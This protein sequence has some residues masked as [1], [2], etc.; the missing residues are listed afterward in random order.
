M[1]QNLNSGKESLFRKLSL[2]SLVSVY[3][4]ILVGGIVRSTGSGMGCPDWPK[5]FDQW[6]PPT[7]SEQLPE[8]YE[9]IYSAKRMAKNERFAKYLSFF[10]L[11]R[12]AEKILNRNSV[13]E[14]TTFNKYKTWTEYFN[15]VLGVLV[16][17][18]ITVT[19]ISSLPLIRRRTGLFVIASLAFIMVVFQGWIGSVVVST[20]L[21]PWMVTVHM[22]LALVIV[23][24]LTLAVFSSRRSLRFNY[25]IFP[26]NIKPL[27][28]IALILMVIQIALGT[29]VREAIDVI[30]SNYNYGNRQQ[31]I[32]ELGLGFYVHRSFSLLILA[33]HVYILYR[34]WK[35]YSQGFIFRLAAVSL[36]VIFVTILS[37]AV[38]AY[39]S[40][41]AFI[42]PLHLMLSSLIF[43]IQFLL[44]LA[45]FKNPVADHYPEFEF[46]S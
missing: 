3:F 21:V 22:L 7:S 14:A 29:Q 39:F 2:L 27:L 35:K 13:S 36:G 42:Q 23:G 46:A 44:L 10:G 15:R 43:G 17:L 26:G 34:V 12:T 25:K 24:L 11:N 30:A 31:W 6:V 33:I 28:F 19:F 38:M 45:V 32:G 18:F 4:L 9:E 1:N 41:P 37:G 8:N 16:G 20:N 5:C 40:I